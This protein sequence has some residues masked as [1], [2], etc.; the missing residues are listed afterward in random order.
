[1]WFGVV[2]LLFIEKILIK[3]YDTS[4]LWYGCFK[5]FLV[6]TTKITLLLKEACVGTAKII[7]LT[8]D[9]SNDPEITPTSYDFFMVKIGKGSKN[10]IV[11]WWRITVKLA[12][13]ATLMVFGSPKGSTLLSIFDLPD[14]NSTQKRIHEDW[15][16]NLMLSFTRI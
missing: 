3:I 9:N 5:S 4:K 14:A 11:S 2:L 10:K 15:A 13:E 16:R 7:S 12:I 8:F 1:M 6:E